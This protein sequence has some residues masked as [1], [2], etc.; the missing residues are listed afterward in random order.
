MPLIYNGEPVQIAEGPAADDR[1]D[2]VIEIAGVITAELRLTELDQVD[3]A[4][5]Y[6]LQVSGDQLLIQ[7]AASADWATATTLLTI[8]ST[9]VTL[10][11]AIGIT[12]NADTPLTVTHTQDAASVQALILQGDR[13]TPADGDEAFTSLLMSDSG[14]TQE[15]VVRLSWAQ[16]DINP[17]ADGRY[18]IDVAQAGTLREAFEAQSSAAGALRLVFGAGGAFTAV[19]GQ[20][21]GGTVAATGMTL[22]APDIITGGAGNIAGADLTFAAGIGIGTGDAAIINFDLPIVAASGDNI[23]TRATRMTLDMA[24]STTE[25]TVNLAQVTNFQAVAGTRV[26]FNGNNVDSDFRVAS[27]NNQTLL[28][29]DGASDNIHLGGGLVTGAFLSITPGAQNRG[30]QTSV[31]WAINLVADTV[32]SSNT[33]TDA[34]GAYAFFGIPTLAGASATYTATVAATVYIE[35]A[36][37]QGSQAS[38]G[39]ALAL[40]I[41]GGDFATDG[42]IIFRGAQDF[43]VAA[44]TQNAF[45]LT[46]GVQAYYDIDT[47]VA[48]SGLDIHIF[49]MA[50]PAFANIPTASITLVSLTGFTFNVTGDAD[51]ITGS[52]PTLLEVNS[53]VLTSATASTNYT[54]VVSSARFQGPQAGTN[55]IL[56][57]MAAIHI[58]D[59]S[60]GAGE[61]AIQSGLQ[62]DTL[63]GGTLNFMLTL[64]S[65]DVDHNLLRVGV[66]GDPIL[67]WDESEDKFSINKGLILTAGRLSQNQGADVASTNNLVLG[68]DGNVFEITGT[69]DI[70]LLSNIGW[71][72]GATVRLLF[73]STAT[74][75]DA[76]TTSTTNITILLDGSVDFVPSAGDTIQLTLCEIGGVQAWRETGSRNVL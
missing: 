24:A 63:A 33:D 71:Q 26:I 14:G 27:D 18:T 52:F 44:A 3:P 59:R 62:I 25:L 64:G 12:H 29:I 38:I 42:N 16:L 5:R 75:K 53:A 2:E 11:G 72:N 45:Q 39:T 22:R 55:V 28:S 73:T 8:T 56:D 10:S 6:R 19:Y 60:D 49:A 46:D 74:V 48:T 47:R 1:T 69:T 50:D 76:Q 68:A 23:Q 4:G 58:R 21:E 57:Q 43:V 20:G 30:L 17:S 7:R 37:I 36:P 65:S 35:G 51:D 61:S 70:N 40:L 34:I 41:D 15:E 32:T 31:G 67:L 13:A 9:G 54:A 66:T